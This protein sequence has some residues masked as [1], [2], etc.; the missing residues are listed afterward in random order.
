MVDS[1]FLSIFAAGLAAV[2]PP[3][4]RRHRDHLRQPW[5]KQPWETTG[6]FWVPLM[7][8]KDLWNMER[9]NRGESEIP[10]IPGM[11]FYFPAIPVVP[12]VEVVCSGEVQTASPQGMFD[13]VMKTGF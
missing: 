3:V 5:G 4:P 7:C 13:R 8:H 2:S 9:W 10:G 6:F 12:V 11:Q 1:P